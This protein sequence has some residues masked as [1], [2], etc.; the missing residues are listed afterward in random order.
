MKG[1]LAFASLVAMGSAR[2]IIP[3]LTDNYGTVAA[4]DCHENYGNQSQCDA[5]S[6]C[7]WCKSGAVASACYNKDD[8]RSLPPAVFVCDG[9]QKALYDE[10]CN[11]NYGNQQSCDADSS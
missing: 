4:T 6:S 11:D 5:D 9:I 10:D 1:A 2:L 8:A 7:T 3:G